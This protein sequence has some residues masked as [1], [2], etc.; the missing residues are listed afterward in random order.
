MGLEPDRGYV[1]MQVQ[2]LAS[3]SGA[4]SC[5]V[6]CRCGWDPALL[7]QWCRLVA[8]DPIQPLA[9]KLPYAAGAVLNK[10]E[11]K[12]TSIYCTTRGYSQC[13]IVIINEV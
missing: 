13:F 5:D 10:G 8:T 7:W 9:Q 6:G 1:R 4:G 12:A 11:K 3:L 2:S